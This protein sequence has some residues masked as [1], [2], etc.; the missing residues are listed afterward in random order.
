MENIQIDNPFSVPNVRKKNVVIFSFSGPD[1]CLSPC[2]SFSVG[3]LMH[4]MHDLTVIRIVFG[5]YFM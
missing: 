2:V 5:S 1:T 4:G 3:T